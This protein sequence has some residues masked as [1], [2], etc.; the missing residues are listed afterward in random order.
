MPQ[1]Q[2]EVPVLLVSPVEVVNPSGEVTDHVHVRQQLLPLLPV[3][4]QPQ[5]QLV[6]LAQIGILL[7][8][9]LIDQGVQSVGEF[10]GV[11][12]KGEN[13]HKEEEHRDCVGRSD[14]LRVSDLE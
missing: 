1:G 11:F 14:E 13:N 9:D 7:N 12:I 8:R 4:F 5:Q 10:H 3:V 2:L 6:N